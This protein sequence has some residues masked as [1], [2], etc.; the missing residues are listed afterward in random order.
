M[1]ETRDVITILIAIIGSGG[2]WTALQYHWQRRDDRRLKS[3]QACS[4]ER[5]AML[6]LLHD[7]IYASTTEIIER[8]EVTVEELDNLGYLYRPYKALGGNGTGE[9]LIKDVAKLPVRKEKNH[10]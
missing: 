6:A 4:T 8:G 3:E 9:K 5:K 7:R 2:F 1:V 10:D